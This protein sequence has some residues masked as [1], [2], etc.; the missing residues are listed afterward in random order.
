[1]HVARAPQSTL[2][3]RPE[4]R[5]PAGEAKRSGGTCCSAHARRR[6][7]PSAQAAPVTPVRYRRRTHSRPHP[8]W[9][10]GQSPRTLP[11]PPG[12][13]LHRP[14]G[15]DCHCNQSSRHA[16]PRQ[17]SPNGRVLT[18]PVIPTG[19][20]RPGRA[21]NGVEGPAVRTAGQYVTSDNRYYVKRQVA[22]Y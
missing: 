3:S 19:V 11:R 1:M 13:S 9:P 15:T 18:N 4:F 17:N 2:S 5:I 7:H 20:S 21:R 8:R 22:G 16:I 12:E 14:K 10:S 6:V